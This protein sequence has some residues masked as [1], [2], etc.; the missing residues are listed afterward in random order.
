MR[1]KNNLFIIFT[2]LVAVVPFAAQ[3]YEYGPDPRYTAAPG[4]NPT[5]CISSGCHVGKVNSGTGGVKIIL[6][7]GTTY[8]PGQAMTISV[9]VTDATKVKFG[10][11]MTARLASSTANGQAGDFTTG[12]DGFTQVKCDDGSVKKNGS[13]CSTQFPVE[14]IEHTLNGYEASTKGGY[15]FTFTWT[16]P[17]AS[18]GSVILYAA[19]N[20]GPGDPPV[21]TPTNVY[22]TNVT[23]T[24]GASTPAPAI[25]SALNA[26]T[27]Q[28][29]IAASTYVALYG[30]GLSTT[31]PGRT[32]AAADFTAN[33]NGTQS[34]PTSLDGTTVTVGGVP[35]YVEYVSPTQLNIVTPCESRDGERRSCRGQLERSA[36]RGVFSHAAKPSPPPSSLGLRRRRTSGNTSS[37]SIANYSNVGKVVAIPGTPAT[38]TTPAVPGETILLYGTG[39]GPTSSANRRRN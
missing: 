16:P 4:D 6:P 10:F 29:T 3:A 33:S 39:F 37:R 11:E 22:T 17:A 2:L 25:S 23:L 31:N 27:G 24:P 26:A 12:S 8:T 21:T 36:E 18:A 19:G 13:P 9:Q 38:F 30:T 15:T 7:N 14:F 34:M 5:A 32:W 28:A 20:A 1:R 35:A